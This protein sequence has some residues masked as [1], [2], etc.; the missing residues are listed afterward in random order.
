MAWIQ[1]EQTIYSP[2][3][4]YQYQYSYISGDGST[5]IVGSSQP[6][7]PIDEPY[8]V[9]VFSW[10]GISWVQKVNTFNYFSSESSGYPFCSNYNGSFIAITFLLP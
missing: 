6:Q 9:K 5:I 1:K 7:E 3:N 8:Y 10:N 2:L 4:N